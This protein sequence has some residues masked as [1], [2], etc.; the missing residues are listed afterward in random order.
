MPAEPV[1]RNASGGRPRSDPVTLA[2]KLSKDLQVEKGS[3]Y[4]AYCGNNKTRGHR[5][6]T[7]D[8]R[9]TSVTQDWHYV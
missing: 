6:D 8:W 3:T 4:P 1:V 2:F 5:E 7:P 9:W